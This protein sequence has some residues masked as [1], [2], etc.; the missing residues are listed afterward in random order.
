MLSAMGNCL[1]V[2][3]QSKNIVYY[4]ELYHPGTA[5][6][7]LQRVVDTSSIVIDLLSFD[8]THPA[9]FSL[10]E[11]TSSSQTK[12]SQYSLASQIMQC[13]INGL[14]FIDLK[15][16]LVVPAEYISFFIL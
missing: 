6:T 2:L 11:F 16:D 8:P 12:L 4:Y 15:K 5:P 10:F 3:R 1:G 9:L 14:D 13:N 7:G